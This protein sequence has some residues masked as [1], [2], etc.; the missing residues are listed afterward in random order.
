MNDREYDPGAK[1]M[2]NNDSIVRT[3]RKEIL[4]NH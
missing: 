3:S 4:P 1:Y 2:Y